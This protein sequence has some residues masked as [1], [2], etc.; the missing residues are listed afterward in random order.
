MKRCTTTWRTQNLN[1]VG[2][3]VSKNYGRESNTAAD[4]TR[5]IS[6]S[7]LLSKVITGTIGLENWPTSFLALGV[8]SSCFVISSVS[9][10]TA[11]VVASWFLDGHY[12][13]TRWGFLVDHWLLGIIFGQAIA[14]RKKSVL[15]R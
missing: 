15:A 13:L 12:P 1:E 4:D 6:L 5:T 8:A 9:H 3:R 10:P 2:T 14:L 11:A 7:V